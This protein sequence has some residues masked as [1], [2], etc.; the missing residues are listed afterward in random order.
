MNLTRHCARLLIA[1]LLL[2]PALAGCRPGADSAGSGA[3]GLQEGGLADLEGRVEVDGSSTVYP[4]S[5]AAAADFKKQFPNVNVTVAVSGTGGGFKR[6][7]KGEID[8]SNAS[9]P[10]KGEEFDVCRS[11]SVS[12]VEVPIAFDGLT[13]AVNPDNDWVDQL[14]VD[15]LKQIYLKDGAQ[16]WS[17]VREGWPDTPIKVFSPGKDSGTFDYFKEVMVGS[18][19]ASMRDDMSE[20]EDDNFLVT[21]VAGEKGAIAFFGAAYLF[22]NQERV[23]AVPIVNPETGAAVSPTPETIESGE[24]APFSRPLFIYVSLESLKRPEVR[25]FAEFQ[26]EQAAK[27]APSVGYVGLPAAMYQRAS[28]HLENRATGTHFITPEGG[29]RTG[30]LDTVY[31]QDNLVDI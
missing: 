17:D 18:S 21:G 30:D 25:K 26:I 6:F 1:V 5:E 4:F 31:T 29:K 16:K 13:I 28:E 12:F 20:S 22:E 24:Y 3:N 23:R 10:I 15:Q 2:T 9:R 8:M 14:T 19:D 11:N 7:A 27:L